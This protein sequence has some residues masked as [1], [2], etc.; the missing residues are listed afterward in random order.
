MPHSSLNKIRENYALSLH[1]VGLGL[2]SVEELDAEHLK[3]VKQTIDRYEPSLVSEHLCWGRAKSKHHNDLLPLPYTEEAIALMVERIDQFQSYLGR[4][5][6]IENVSSY[7]Q[8]EHSHMP[9]WEF[10]NAIVEKS[11]CGLLLDIN[12][13]FVSSQNFKFNA[14]DFIQAINVDSVKEMHLAGHE[15]VGHTLIDTHGKAPCDEVWCLYKQALNQFGRVPTLI[16]WDTDIPSL[17]TLLD[18]AAK[19]DACL[20]A[21]EV[22]G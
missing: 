5:V 8:F 11:G 13:I 20:N 1:G 15:D 19:A 3:K 7:L 12:N 4:Q 2:G 9:E 22:S 10:I 16:E 14:I 17:Q 18:E 21:C 6:L